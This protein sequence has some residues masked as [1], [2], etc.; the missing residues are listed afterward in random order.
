MAQAEAPSSSN[1]LPGEVTRILQQWNGGSDEALQELMEKVYHELRAV[2]GGFF[3]DAPVD[4][5]MQ[6]TELIGEVYLRMLAN[7]QFR[8]DN[9][10]QF[11][12]FAGQL[13]RH[14]VVEQARARRRLK[15][16]GPEEPMPLSALPEPAQNQGW[17]LE[18][19]LAVDGA[20][21]KL[22][23]RDPRQA[24]IVTLRFFAGASVEEVAEALELSPA[25]VKR[26]W[27]MARHWLARELSR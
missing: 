1:P 6:P 4:A 7:R 22:E 20:L 9:R 12:W 3:R 14:I 17:D 15:R 18:T 24:K 11:F 5:L 8:F 25:T 19:L 10:C 21:N 13:M 2:A 27:R 16:G 26:E 23:A